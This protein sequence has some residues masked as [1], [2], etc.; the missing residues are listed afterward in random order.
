[1]YC[2]NCAAEI[3]VDQQFCRSCGNVLVQE[4]TDSRFNFRYLGLV[5]F[6]AIFLGV[7]A[8]VSGKMFAV[9]WVSL[10]GIFVSLASLFSLM[11]GAFLL[12][13]RPQRRRSYPNST[14]PQILAADKTS[15]LLPVGVNDFIPGVTEKTTDLLKEPAN[16]D[17]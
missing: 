2:S 8:A 6:L 12:A 10:V 17:R 9:K 11:I 15:K 7:I 4:N 13:T 5:A 1:M 3:S 14:E 16:I